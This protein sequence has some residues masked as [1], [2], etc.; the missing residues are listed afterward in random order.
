MV[1]RMELFSAAYVIEDADVAIAPA[2]YHEFR[3]E[4]VSSLAPR[5]EVDVT[6]ANGQPWRGAFFGGRDELDTVANSPSPDHLIAV[7]GG[8]V[9]AVAVSTPES[10]DVI[11]LRPVR[12]VEASES[13]G[14]VVLVGFNSVIA[15]G[16]TGRVE[17]GSDRL[18]SDGFTEVRLSIDSIVLR[19]Y[20]APS[21]TDVETTL[22]LSNGELLD[23]R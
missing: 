14:V 2:T 13:A 3:T 9:Y 1:E 17:W 19:G 23:R 4:G 5:F 15:V 6:P 11:P 18:V 7:A 16:G 12:S 22:S 10:Y 20:D 8:V 21:D